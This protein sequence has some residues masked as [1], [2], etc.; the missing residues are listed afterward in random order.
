MNKEEPF[1]ESGPGGSPAFMQQETQR[2]QE[3]MVRAWLQVIDF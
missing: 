1:Q 3:Y 2:V